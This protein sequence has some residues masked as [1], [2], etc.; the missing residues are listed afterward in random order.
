MAIQIAKKGSSDQ[1][2][3]VALEQTLNGALQGKPDVVRLSLIALFAKGH[4]LVE[5]VPGVGKTTLARSLARAL[6]GTFNRIQFTS[7]MLPADILGVS[8]FDPEGKRFDFHPG[9]IF[10]NVVLA[11]EVNRTTPRTQ[12]ALLEAMSEVSVTVEGEVRPLPQPFVVLATQNP[13]EQHGTYPLPESQMDRFLLRLT[14]GYPDAD[15]ELSVLRAFGHNDA[16][17]SV[18]QILSPEL[19]TQHQEAVSKIAIADDVGQGLLEI[20]RATREHS[21]LSLGVSPRGSIALY[22]AAQAK[23]YLEGR[24]FVTPDDVRSLVIP[25]FA[26]RIVA[27][28]SGRDG[29]RSTEEAILLEIMEQLSV[30]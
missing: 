29:Q 23:A 1:A 25:C 30:A 7:D 27:R 3:L 2:S 5:D 14:I 13:K 18:E 15:A 10:A 17:D 12:S 24:T 21:D 20:V 4:I 9:P 8:I 26:H 19:L 11:D 28:S 22:R 16:A 6:G